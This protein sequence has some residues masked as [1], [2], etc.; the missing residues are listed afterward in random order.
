MSIRTR[1]A[2]FLLKEHTQK[3][4]QAASI[5][6]EAY[7]RGPLILTP[8][9]MLR[10]LSELDSRLVDMLVRQMDTQYGPGG[11]HYEPNEQDRVR[12]VD[13]SRRLYDNDPITQTVIDTWTDFAFGMAVEVVPKDEG[14]QA[15]WDE[16]IQ[17]DRN[18]Y[19]LGADNIQENSTQVLKDGDMLFLFFI[20]TM[21]GQVTVRTVPTQELKGG[22]KGDG[23]ITHPEDARIVLYYRREYLPGGTG[24]VPSVIY[25]RDWRATDA[26]LSTANL[27]FVDGALADTLPGNQFTDGT[28][29]TVVKAMFVAP[30]PYGRRGKPLLMAGFDW[31]IAYRDFMQDRLA[32]SK[33]ISTYVDKIK[34]KGGSR[35]IDAIQ[36]RLESSLTQSGQGW[37]RNPPP[38]AGSTWLEN[39]ALE[40]SRFNLTTGAVDAEKDG[41]KFLSMAGMSARIY[42]H[43]LGQGEAFRL[44]TASAME[45][46]TLK[47]FKR[48]QLFWKAQFEHMAKIVLQAA[49]DYGSESFST[50]EVTVSLDPILTPDYKAVLALM[51]GIREAVSNGLLDAQTGD[52]LTRILLELAM[53][54][55]GVKELELLKPRAAENIPLLKVGFGENALMVEDGRSDLRSGL[56]AA[57]RGYWSAKTDLLDFIDGI[58]ATLERNYRRAWLEGLAEFGIT[59]LDMTDEEKQAL[60]LEINNQLAYVLD[61]A[62]AIHKGNKENGGKLEVFF[63]RVELWVNRYDQIVSLARAMA[64]ADKPLEWVMGE[65]EHCQSCLKLAGK[66]KRASYWKRAGILPATPNATFLEC[67]GFQCACELK[68]TAKPISKGPLPR[69][70]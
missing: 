7:E 68:S 52:E 67:K 54:N 62:E 17:A 55:L 59:E 51:T 12:V 34:V 57:V 16:F 8:E 60:N 11:W 46:P 5:F 56:R 30:R 45:M 53:Q 31:S 48:Y 6:M 69:L 10:R 2:E 42:P 66:V 35:V 25:Y 43:W 37:D 65:A 50:Y 28:A 40:R 39:E 63:R 9:N 32:I 22:P 14:A 58:T 3:Y 64:G 19:V 61:F 15:A 49:E 1:I 27:K 44:A 36:A 47:A 4:Q 23:L 18:A 33:A 70:P 29:K 13:L 21:T 20:S 26:Q 38:T 24:A 41:A